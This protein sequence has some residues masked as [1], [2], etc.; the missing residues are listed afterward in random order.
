M[1]ASALTYLLDSAFK[2]NQEKF[3]ACILYYGVLP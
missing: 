3:D 1:G 2:Y